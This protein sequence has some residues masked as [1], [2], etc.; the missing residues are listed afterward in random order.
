MILKKNC[1][2]AFCKTP[3][4]VYLKRRTNSFNIL[5]SFVGSLM[6]MGL[7]WMRFDFR[8]IIVFLIFMLVTEMFIQVRWR[9]GIICRSCGFDPVVYLNSPTRAAEK[10]KL[11]FEKKKNNPYALN[12]R[13]ENLPTITSARLEEVTAQLPSRLSK[14]I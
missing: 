8:F 1:F 5:A 14:T 2:C 13:P 11:F 10:V 12:L 4:K 9:L 3:R 6:F 7:F